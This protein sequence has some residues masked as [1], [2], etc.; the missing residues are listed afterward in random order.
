[1]RM[2]NACDICDNEKECIRLDDDRPKYENNVIY[3]CKDCL[4]EALEE[5]E[6]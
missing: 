5:I 6:N 4:T 3:I 2:K 1:M